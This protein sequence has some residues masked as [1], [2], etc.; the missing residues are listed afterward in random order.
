[1]DDPDASDRDRIRAAVAIL[2]RAVGR[3]AQA[4]EVAAVEV[5]EPPEEPSALHVAALARVD[6]L[7]AAAGEDE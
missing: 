6:A 1:M 2:D 3:P 5:A 4:V 7:L